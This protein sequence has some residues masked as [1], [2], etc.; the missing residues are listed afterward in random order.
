MAE[1]LAR[2]R[3]ALRR[4]VRAGGGDPLVR[5]GDLT[6]D[7]A[8]RTVSKAGARLVL[9][10]KEFRVLQALAMHAGNVVTHQ[11]LLN[12]VWG[13]GHRQDTHYLRIFIRKLRGKIED[14]PTRPQLLITEL[15]VGYR[16]AQEGE[17][18]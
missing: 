9:T 10:P 4:H 11:Q 5:A 15:G 18:G 1:L 13:A 8:T 3:A 6:I 14:N 17:S 7:L 16:L 12:E 2:A